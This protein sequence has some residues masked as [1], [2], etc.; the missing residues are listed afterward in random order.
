M[1][2]DPDSSTQ[3]M[4]CCVGGLACAGNV[5]LSAH[6]A[7]LLTS[8]T[9]AGLGTAVGTAPVKNQQNS[10]SAAGDARG[11]TYHVSGLLFAGITATGDDELATEVESWL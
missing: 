4:P 6:G 2:V 9:L 10:G 11:L 3:A 1:A 8:I 5:K 7:A